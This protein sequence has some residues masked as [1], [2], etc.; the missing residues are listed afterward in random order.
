MDYSLVKSLEGYVCT[1]GM[2][3]GKIVEVRGN[4]VE[5]EHKERRILLNLDHVES[6]Q[7][8]SDKYHK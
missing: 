4:W 1:L 8:V 3:K 2:Y 6:I 7:V 5:I